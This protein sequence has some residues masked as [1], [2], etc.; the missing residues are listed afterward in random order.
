MK[1]GCELS[2]EVSQSGFTYSKHCWLREMKLFLKG[3]DEQE[4]GGK[5][6]RASE[7]ILHRQRLQVPTLGLKPKH[8]GVPME[9]TSQSSTAHSIKTLQRALPKSATRLDAANPYIFCLSLKA[10]LTGEEKGELFKKA[11]RGSKTIL[12]WMSEYKKMIL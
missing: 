12:V 4:E 8:K 9:S 6:N 11:W 10:E 5:K 7:Q 3:D 1:N 2:T